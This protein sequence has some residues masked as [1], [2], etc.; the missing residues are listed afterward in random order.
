MI[1]TAISVTVKR[2]TMTQ[3]QKAEKNRNGLRLI[4][5]KCSIDAR[6]DLESA[7]QAKENFYKLTNRR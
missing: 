6:D 2:Q 1:E 7:G 4:E 3:R 5:V